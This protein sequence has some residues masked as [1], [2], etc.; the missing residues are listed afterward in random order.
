MSWQYT[1]QKADSGLLEKLEPKE[2]SEV[3]PCVE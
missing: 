3:G 2:L 1:L